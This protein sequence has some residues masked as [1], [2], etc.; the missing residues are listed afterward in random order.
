MRHSSVGTTPSS[1]TSKSHTGARRRIM[2]WLTAVVL[3]AGW[4][5]FTFFSQSFSMQ[6]QNS[7]LQQKL[8]A[9]QAAQAAENQ[10]KYEVNR[11]QDPEFIGELARS[12]YGL[13]K[14]EE[15]PILNEQK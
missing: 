13:Y 5:I 11:L 9:Q 8:A 6:E 12:R 1:S 15:T 14:P 3:F 10:L 4:T 7:A 2:I